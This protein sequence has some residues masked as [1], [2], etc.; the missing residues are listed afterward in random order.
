MRFTTVG[1][2]VTLVANTAAADVVGAPPEVC[3]R[4][5]TPQT[6]HH[7]PYCEPP[8]P[9]NCPKGHTPGVDRDVTFCEPPPKVCPQGSR[10]VRVTGLT[11][12]PFC[13]SDQCATFS[14]GSK[15]PQRS[16]QRCLQLGLCVAAT[17]R[18]SRL[19]TGPRGRD[20]KLEVV[21]GS[22]QTD[23][24]CAQGAKC[25]VAKRVVR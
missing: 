15:R 4:G 13:T 14:H 1:L 16:M 7:G 10:S 23:S 12:A 25:I 3:P 21:T 17:P 9:K 6:D 2:V 8:P 19:E 11:G 22:C 18:T 5:H 20:N 24:D